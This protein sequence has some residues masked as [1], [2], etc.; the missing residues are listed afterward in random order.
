[1]SEEIEKNDEIEP[2]LKFDE[3][4]DHIKIEVV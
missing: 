2:E 1:M 4:A 3:I